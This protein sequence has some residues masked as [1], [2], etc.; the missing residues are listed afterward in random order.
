M[1]IW[2]NNL[3][4][5]DPRTCRKCGKQVKQHVIDLGDKTCRISGSCECQQKTETMRDLI[6]KDPI[7]RSNLHYELFEKMEQLSETP[8]S[9]TQDAMQL[10]NELYDIRKRFNSS[11]R[12]LASGNNGL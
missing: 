10:L 12:L 5:E 6:K 9:N 8:I 1:G 4:V 2:N 3:N 11:N 7:L